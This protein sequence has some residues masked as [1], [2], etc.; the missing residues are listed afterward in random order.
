MKKT[1]YFLGSEFRLDRSEES[2]HELRSSYVSKEIAEQSDSYLKIEYDE[3]GRL[4]ESTAFYYGE[5]KDWLSVKNKG[6]AHR[7]QDYELND[8]CEIVRDDSGDSYLGGNPPDEF[9]MPKPASG[10]P[11][12]YLGFLNSMDLLFHIDRDLHLAA[13]LLFD[14]S[15]SVWLD[16]KDPLSPKVINNEDIVLEC[17]IDDLSAASAFCFEKFNI[18]AVS[19]PVVRTRDELGRTGVPSWTQYPEFK[20]CC[21][22]G[23]PMQFV[24]QLSNI[25][26]FGGRIYIFFCKE[27]D[28]ACYHYQGT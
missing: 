15:E 25:P 8:P 10:F 20:M 4:A 17:A 1:Q 14:W 5:P 16:Y 12:Q 7:H 19:G 22:T 11:F 18:K 26:D 28:V 24:C 3:D 23:K 21:N 9:T 2:N 13:P 6:R 27:S